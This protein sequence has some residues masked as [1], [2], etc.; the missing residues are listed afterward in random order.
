MYCMC[1]TDIKTLFFSNVKAGT[2]VGSPVW[3]NRMHTVLG[4]VFPGLASFLK[5]GTGHPS[6]KLAAKVLAYVMHLPVGVSSFATHLPV[7]ADS[8]LSPG[9]CVLLA[10]QTYEPYSS[11]LGEHGGMQCK[12]MGRESLP[13][14]VAN[15][16]LTSL[17][18]SPFEKASNQGQYGV[19]TAR[20]PICDYSSSSCSQRRGVLTAYQ[21]LHWYTQPLGHPGHLLSQDGISLHSTL[22]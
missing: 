1:V 19:C 14:T 11:V 13:E 15:V 5:G 21:Q 9:A 20:F 6:G 10:G 7:G 4:A 3:A 12:S 8:L 18:A 17:I 2:L 16:L 22:C